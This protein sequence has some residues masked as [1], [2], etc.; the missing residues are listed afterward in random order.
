MRNDKI[1]NELDFWYLIAYNGLKS[2]DNYVLVSF[3]NSE[4]RFYISDEKSIGETYGN[5]EHFH[6]IATFGLVF[7]F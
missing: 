5:I 3:Q 7:Y 6:T 1:V 2:S 4:N